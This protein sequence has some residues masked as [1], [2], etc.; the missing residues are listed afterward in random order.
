[1]LRAL[2]IKTDING[3]G[4]VDS[5]EF[6]GLVRELKLNMTDEKVRGGSERAFEYTRVFHVQV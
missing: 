3:N 2:F 5:E 6:L 1:M 4:L